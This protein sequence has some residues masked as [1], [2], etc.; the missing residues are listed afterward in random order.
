MTQ[1]I[2][3]HLDER[4]QKE[5]YFSLMITFEIKCYEKDW[6]F[7]LRT[8][9][10]E[11]LLKRCNYD[12]ARRILYINN[13]E[14]YAA[15]EK[16]AKQLVQKGTIDEYIRVSDYEDQVLDFFGLTKEEF[17]GG[18]YYSIAELTG[19][20]LCRTE[21]LVHFSSDAMLEVGPYPW[22]NSAINQMSL[23]K[24]VLVAFPNYHSAKEE[25]I[26]DDDDWYYGYGF[27]DQ[28]YLIRIADFKKRIYQEYNPDSERYPKYGGEL[29]EK[30]VD[31]YMRNH[32]LLRM[33]SKHRAYYHKNFPKKRFALRVLFVRQW[34]SNLISPKH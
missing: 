27:S 18:Y 7:V 2:V 5:I 6:R 31:A 26:K 22:I 9:R 12:F 20:F 30:R 24:D 3:I 28:C 13:V 33:S 1:R 16:Y 23:R 34:L 4:S 10:I 25:S 19:I 21:Y 15:V 8:G 17:K 32:Q 14:D 29:F 11:Q